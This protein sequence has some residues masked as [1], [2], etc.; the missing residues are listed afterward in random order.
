M[1][2][3]IKCYIFWKVLF[4]FILWGRFCKE[5]QTLYLKIDYYY[6]YYFFF[7]FEREIDRIYFEMHKT[8]TKKKL[9]RTS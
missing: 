8:T 9:I 3:F 1:G 7:P 6:S 4:N 2:I 5:T